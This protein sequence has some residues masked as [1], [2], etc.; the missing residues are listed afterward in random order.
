[1]IIEHA[2]RI[3]QKSLLEIIHPDWFENVTRFPENAFPCTKNC[4]DYKISVR[5]GLNGMKQKTVVIAGLCINIEKK[6]PKLL[7]RIKH[8]G[9]FFKEYKFIVFEN[10]SSDRTRELLHDNDVILVPCEE[11]VNCKLKYKKAVSHGATSRGR[12]MKM[13]SYRNRLITFI[14]KNFYEYD[15]VCFMDLDL[16]GPIDIRGVAHSFSLY[17]T[18]DAISAQGLNGVTLT[19]GLPVYYDPVAYIK[20]GT[21]YLSPN[22]YSVGDSPYKVQSGFCGMAFY[23]MIVIK[24]INYTPDDDKYICEHITFHKNMIKNGFD[25]IFINPNMLLLSG[26]QGDVDTFPY[27]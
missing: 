9:S 12:I 26:A 22:F 11:D 5:N 20:H 8:L 18:W 21:T 14:N 15:T 6:I 25:N 3:K 4:N 24:S 27:Y 1:M 10:D 16:D 13:T 7:E 2:C 17:D 19:F 23:K